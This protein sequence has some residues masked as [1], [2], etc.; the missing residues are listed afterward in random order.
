VTGSSRRNKRKNFRPRNIVYNATDDDAGTNNNDNNGHNN[1]N[2]VDDDDDN[3][4]DDSRDECY[5]TFC[6]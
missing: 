5:K 1:N 6:S 4:D 3:D 2:D